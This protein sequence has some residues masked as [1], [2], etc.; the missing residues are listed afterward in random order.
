[1]DLT[2]VALGEETVKRGFSQCPQL[3][4]WPPL[5]VTRT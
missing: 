4:C 3:S 5:F 1:L 2:G